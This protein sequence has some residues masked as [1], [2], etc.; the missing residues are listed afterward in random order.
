MF[1][2]ETG[3]NFLTLPDSTAKMRKFVLVLLLTLVFYPAFTQQVNKDFNRILVDE[4][5][6]RL[7]GK[8]KQESNIDNQFI[9]GDDGFSVWR[10]NEKSGY[11]IFPEKNTEYGVYE[12]QI[13]FDFDKNAQSSQSVGLVLQ[14]QPDG[15]GA[16]VVELSKKRQ[17]RIRRAMGNTLVN[18]S[19]SGE[20]WL[21]AKK[22]ITQGRNVLSIRTYDKIYDIYINDQ[23]IRTFTEV[24][25]SKGL[26]GLYIGAGSRAVFKQLVI[27]TDDEH[28]NPDLNNNTPIDEQKALAQAIVKLKETINKKDKRIT[29]LETQVRTGGGGGRRADSMLIRQAEEATIRAAQ[30]NGEL[31]QSK[32]E[33]GRLKETVER[34][35]TFRKNITESENGDVIINLTN[36]NQRQKE[37]IELL[38]ATIKSLEKNVADLKQEKA[39]LTRDVN[40]SRAESDQLRNSSLLLQVQ[41]IEKDSIIL[42]QEARIQ[43]TDDALA[44]C[45]K[46]LPKEERPAKEPKKSKRKEKEEIKQEKGLFDE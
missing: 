26:I 24:E 8:W 2:L 46:H 10:K 29:E 35:E 22:Q 14:A 20:G 41:M 1:R 9:G 45:S 31:E 21:K 11:F 36:M 4:Q 32:S 23:Y 16:I 27:K 18:I 25:Y 13:T 30:L 5:F 37:Q 28:A 7:D 33:N 12:V 43:K 44:K 19:G 39:E 34:L 3:Q 42:A 6:V 17:Y 40:K 38:Q 15:T